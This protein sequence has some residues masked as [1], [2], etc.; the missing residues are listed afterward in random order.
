MKQIAIYPGTFDPITY[1]HIDII[2]R[3]SHLFAEVVIAIADSPNKN[4]LF[5]LDERLLLAK[6]AVNHHPNVGVV[7]FNNL[8]L[9]FAKG[10]QA[11]VIIRGIRSLADFEYESQ[12]ASINRRLA[13]HLD[14]VFLLPADNHKLISSSF[15]RE[16]ASLN[17]DIN[18]FVPPMIASALHSKFAK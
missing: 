6:A 17:G 10:M 8:L 7:G 15:V 13:P 4:P 5:S 12:M 11:T 16:I 1:G 14:T 9:D 2:E 3:A 18:S